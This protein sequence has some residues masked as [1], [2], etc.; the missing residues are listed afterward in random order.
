[1]Q[2]TGEKLAFDTFGTGEFFSELLKKFSQERD[3]EG[4]NTTT[5]DRQE[6]KIPGDITQTSYDCGYKHML[7]PSKHCQ[8][9]KL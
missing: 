1:M 3:K 5:K 9:P 2:P 7:Q 8:S 4:R 6:L